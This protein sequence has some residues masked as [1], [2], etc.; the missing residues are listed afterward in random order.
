LKKLARHF[1][2]CSRQGKMKSPGDDSRRIVSLKTGIIKM[3]FINKNQRWHKRG[4]EQARPEMVR[5]A[6]ITGCPATEGKD[7]LMSS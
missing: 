3:S 5:P 6:V 2:S 7:N 1:T 4:Q